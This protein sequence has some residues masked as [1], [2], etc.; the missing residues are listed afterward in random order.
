VKAPS[1]SATA[2]S[3]AVKPR[4]PAPPASIA[5]SHAAG[6]PPSQTPKPTP[7]AS[8]P[9]VPSVPDETLR[10]VKTATRPVASSASKG[11]EGATK[12]AVA[13]K[14]T[15]SLPGVLSVIMRVFPYLGL[16]YVLFLACIESAPSFTLV[17]GIV[18]LIVGLA[19]IGTRLVVFPVPP[20]VK[21]AL[22]AITMVLGDLLLVGASLVSLGLGWILWTS[23]NASGTVALSWLSVLLLLA[24]MFA[25]FLATWRHTRAQAVLS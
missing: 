10:P 17:V 22:A 21:D 1:K 6:A 20:L 12:A 18:A 14:Q 2:T 25:L 19:L 5:R 16:E 7:V 4:S 23:W 15:I 24:A 13:P 11:K 8:A 9:V 3:V